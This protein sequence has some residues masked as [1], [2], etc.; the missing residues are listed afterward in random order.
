M[1]VLFSTNILPS[2]LADADN[3]CLN[4]LLS[5]QAFFKNGD[6][7]FL[8]FVTLISQ[9]YY[10][11]N[12]FSSLAL[13]RQIIKYFLKSIPCITVLYYYYFF[14]IFKWLK[15]FPVGP[16]QVSSHVVLMWALDFRTLAPKWSTRFT[17]YYPY[18]RPRP[19]PRYFSKKLM[20]FSENGI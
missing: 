12:N 20:I 19:R 17:L 15:V 8:S 7:L 11:R 3:L 2:T 4:Q 16:L 13:S 6:F 1:N 14:L 5:Q 10:N 9:C 18:S